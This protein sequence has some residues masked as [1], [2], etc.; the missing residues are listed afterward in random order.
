[1]KLASEVM[2]KAKDIFVISLHLHQVSRHC[3][4][5]HFSTLDSK[6]T[7]IPIVAQKIFSLA[8]RELYW[9]LPVE[10][11]KG[12]AQVNSLILA[13]CNDLVFQVWHPC[14]HTIVL[15]PLCFAIICFRIAVV[16]RAGI[17]DL[18]C[19]K[20][21]IFSDGNVWII[22]KVHFI[23]HS[24]ESTKTLSTFRQ[25]FHSEWVLRPCE[26]VRADLLTLQSSRW[27][28]DA[29]LA[30]HFRILNHRQLL[31]YR[32][33]YPLLCAKKGDFEIAEGVWEWSQT[34]GGA[35]VLEDLKLS[36]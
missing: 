32:K 11:I 13:K 7:W 33:R 23:M 35:F 12:F 36:V 20:L 19:E 27:K 28:T 17:S 9:N 2:L 6:L 22:D 16:F 1:M 21:S 4:V 30:T 24:E 5:L 10:I 26:I 15:E 8:K 25:A 29:H 18:D 34:L 14:W 31:L 3:F